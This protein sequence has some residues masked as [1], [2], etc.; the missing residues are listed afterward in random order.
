MTFVKSKELQEEVDTLITTAKAKGIAG[1]PVVIIDGK[2]KLDGV[3]PKDTYLQVRTYR[4]P[5]LL[6]TYPI[7]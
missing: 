4:I 7:S 1:S 3:Q 2:F 6:F 5:R